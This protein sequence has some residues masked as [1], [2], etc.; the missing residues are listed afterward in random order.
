M[1][2]AFCGTKP[3]QIIVLHNSLKFADCMEGG[4]QQSALAAARSIEEA[5]DPVNDR[6]SGVLQALLAGYRI[7]FLEGTFK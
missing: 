2:E 4:N 7:T 6:F 3:A 1:A 5:V